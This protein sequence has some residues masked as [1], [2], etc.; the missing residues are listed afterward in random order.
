MNMRPKYQNTRLFS[1]L[2][3]PLKNIVFMTQRFLPAIL[4]VLLMSFLSACSDKFN[5]AAPYKNITVVNAI[6][7]MGDTAHYVRVEKAFLDQNKNA[8]VMATVP[9]SNFY[10]QL[11]VVVK[12]VNQFNFVVNTYTLYRVDMDAE[13]YPKDP[14][15]F[16]NSPNYAYKFKNALNPVDSFRIVITNTASGEVDS[17]TSA[18]IDVNGFQ[19]IQF[20][21][22]SYKI[23]L[24]GTNPNQKFDLGG[25]LPSQAVVYQGIMRI[26]WI[27]S[28]GTSSTPKY[29]D[30]N[31]TSLQTPTNA[32]NFDLS[33]ADLNF[34]YFLR[35]NMGAPSPGVNRYL[36]GVDMFIYAGSSSLYNYQ[37]L[38][39]SAGTGIA[40]LNSQP[41]YTNIRGKSV[42]GLYGST[43]TIA[44]YNIDFD[45]ATKDSLVSSPT[46]QGIIAGLNIVGF[47]R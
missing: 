32:N 9:D 44:D 13:G 39:L 4:L 38:A 33:T 45:L 43:G 2:C 6:F 26:H 41:V 42:T 7:N 46:L 40:G 37:Q 19:V 23:S 21:N 17:S 28:T 14:G 34:Y 30:W 25:N 24:Y 8:L 1:Y 20:N 12:E 36:Q 31:F 11:N 5:V 35:D 22:I 18:I 15:T 47:T 27:D 29:L 10:T 16:F 3:Q